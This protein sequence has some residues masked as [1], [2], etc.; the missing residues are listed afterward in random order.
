LGATEASRV[1]VDRATGSCFGAEAAA[2]GAGS[3]GRARTRT[4]WTSLGSSR[5]SPPSSVLLEESEALFPTGAPDQHPGRMK[6]RI[7]ATRGSIHLRL[8][9]TAFTGGIN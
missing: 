5:F 1:G 2:T 7:N 8:R 6:M 4:T 9:G 3:G